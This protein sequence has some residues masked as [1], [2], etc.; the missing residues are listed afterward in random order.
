MANHVPIHAEIIG[1]NDH[2]SHYVFDSLFQ[3]T[4]DIQPEIHSTD[5][6]GTNEVNFALLNMVGYQCAPRY[7]DIYDKVGAA[8]YGFKHPS[9]Y[10]E[11]MV[12]KPIRKLSPELIIEEWENMQRILM[13]VAFKTTTQSTIVRK[14]SAFAR[15]IRRGA[16]CGN[17][18]TS[19]AACTC[20]TTLTR[21]PSGAMS[22][23]LS[24]EARVPLSCVE[25]SR[26]P[27]SASCDSRQRMSNTSGENVHV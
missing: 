11:A 23:R 2:E 20:L 21:R 18:T 1:A 4:T 7:R 16:P 25:P 14:L 12:L 10:D 5:T 6:H 24:P 27:T 15:K 19:S 17:M 3:N 22:S 9:Q 8:L 26:T 13:S